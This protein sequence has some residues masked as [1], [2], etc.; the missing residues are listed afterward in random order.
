M[1][2]L[3]FEDQIKLNEI[4]TTFDPIDEPIES[5]QNYFSFLNSRKERDKK[6]SKN[7]GGKNG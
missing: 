6:R 3:N 1:D 7:R 2:D 4:M 5:P